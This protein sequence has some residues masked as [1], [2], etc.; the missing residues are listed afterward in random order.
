MRWLLDA[1][2]TFAMHGRCPKKC[3]VSRGMASG[4]PALF[5]RAG[6]HGWFL[7]MTERGAVPLLSAGLYSALFLHPGSLSGG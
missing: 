5:K 6:T 4:S 3:S 1:K 7:G 2:S